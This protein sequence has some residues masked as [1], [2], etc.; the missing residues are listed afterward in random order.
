M[1]TIKGTTVTKPSVYWNKVRGYEVP[2]FIKPRTHLSDTY[3]ENP[4]PKPEDVIPTSSVTFTYDQPTNLLT[5]LWNMQETIGQTRRQVTK[6]GLGLY[7]KVDDV[8]N[9]QTKNERE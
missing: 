8:S 5:T 1:T 9:I 7:P 2:H 6:E 4:Q 3:I